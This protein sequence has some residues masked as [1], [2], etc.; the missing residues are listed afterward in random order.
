[1]RI[2]A[3]LFALFALLASPQP[4]HQQKKYPWQQEG[5]NCDKL[6]T[7]CWSDSQVTAY[8]N[9]WVAPDKDE[10]PF[11]WV[12]EVRCLKDYKLCIPWN[13]EKE[14]PPRAKGAASWLE[15]SKFRL[16]LK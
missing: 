9:R 12:T 6:M 7:F 3:L 8:G 15:Q 1:M 11:E 14:G 4:Q 13:L 10:K 16:Q 2:Y 5:T